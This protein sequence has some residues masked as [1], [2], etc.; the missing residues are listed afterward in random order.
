MEKV[1]VAVIGLGLR[2]HGILCHLLVH[3]DNVSVVSVCDVYEDRVKEAADRVDL[4]DP[5]GTPFHLFSAWAL[6]SSSST[7]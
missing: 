4:P 5:A 3:M 1:N 7:R 2:G 6:A